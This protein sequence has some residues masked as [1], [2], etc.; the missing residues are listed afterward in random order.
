MKYPYLLLIGAF[1]LT[2]F[3][4]CKK[5][6]E[7]NP[8]AEMV[9]ITSIS[10]DM[11]TPGGIVTITGKNFGGDVSKVSLLLDDYA[12][13]PI[14]A[15][16][17]TITFKIPENQLTEPGQK[18]YTLSLSVFGK[19][20]SDKRSVTIMLLEKHGWYYPATIPGAGYSDQLCRLITFPTDSIGFIQKEKSLFR[21]T[22]G[23]ITWKGINDN[24]GFGMGY[25]FYSIDGNHAWAEW[26][27]Q[28]NVSTN[29]TTYKT[30]T[31]QF[32]NSIIIGLYMSSPGRGLVATRAGKLYYIDGS[33]DAANV[34]EAYTSIH[35]SSGSWQKLS[36]ID[37]TNTMLAGTVQI[38]SKS[39]LTI[40]HEK[41]GAFSEY[42]LAAVTT[43]GFAK[44]LQ[45]IDKNTAVLIDGN[46]DL[47]RL[48]GDKNWTKLNQKATAV[49]FKDANTGYAA[50]NGKIMKTTDGG[51]T[52][53][54]E[55]T[56]REGETIY[57]ICSKNGKIWAGGNDA[58]QIIILKYNP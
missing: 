16:N 40:V 25:A 18:T 11:L 27:S 38:N 6:E 4:S 50:Y 3:F 31:T 36:A 48:S 35:Y 30:S 44:A 9:S 47:L 15:T 46:N 41:G 7:S 5:D 17:E 23:G 20:G 33:F 56:L 52:W 55:F 1:V 19:A 54:D 32:G 12:I 24:G 34:Y 43:A 8:Q 45:L 37:E 28:V 57:S 49:Y 26:L 14:S 51:A 10:P 21:T 13:F 22:N 39:T 42:D 29:G 2:L 58:T 53:K